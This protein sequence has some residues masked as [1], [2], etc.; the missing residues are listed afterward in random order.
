M[1]SDLLFTWLP[2]SEAAARLGISERTLDRLISA[3]KG[4]EC[5]NRPR[6]GKKPEPVY[7]PADVDALVE[8]ANK[9]AIFAASSPIGPASTTAL[10]PA[11]G[12]SMPP[13]LATALR[14]IDQLATIAQRPRLDPP[15][16][17]A[18]PWMTID[19]AAAYT[20]LSVTFLRRLVRSGELPSV[21]DRSTKVRRTDLDNL[22]ISDKV[23]GLSRS[24]GV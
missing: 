9:P 11:G 8:A 21:R 13:G 16:P 1:S 19:Q 23:S 22:D 6:P 4:P 5:R 12:S 18:T 7:N 17:A 2:K 24:E 20:G 3:G 14:F 15:V 10:A